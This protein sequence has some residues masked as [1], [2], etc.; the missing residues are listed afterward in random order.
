MGL[1]PSN[2]EDRTPPDMQTPRHEPMIIELDDP[3]PRW[4][5]W[6]AILVAV[7]IAALVI[8]PWLID[9][10]TSTDADA[11]QTQQVQSSGYAPVCRPR[12]DFP[13]FAEPAASV[14]IPSWMRLCDW[15]AEPA[16]QP[17]VLPTQP[18]ND[19]RFID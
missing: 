9:V 11:S 5:R 2:L 6:G 1:Q 3:T 17:V 13:S 19:S 7:V 14:A 12:L 18:A 16:G 10:D 4:F 8:A 15:F